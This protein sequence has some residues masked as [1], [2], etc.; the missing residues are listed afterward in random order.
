MIIGNI[1]F[2]WI[3]IF[4]MIALYHQESKMLYSTHLEWGSGMKLQI[5]FT[6]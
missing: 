1:L 5:P 3:E 4:M 2:M 6:T